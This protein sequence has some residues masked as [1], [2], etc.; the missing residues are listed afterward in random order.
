MDSYGERE[1][2]GEGLSKSKSKVKRQS[3]DTFRI[4]V[5]LARIDLILAKTNSGL[6]LIG[7][8]NWNPE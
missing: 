5:I 6:T 2:E 1:R 3:Q 8:L 7:I 4:D